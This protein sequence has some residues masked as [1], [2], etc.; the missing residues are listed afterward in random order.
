MNSGNGGAN[1]TAMLVIVELGGDLLEYF[2]VASWNEF[3]AEL[4]RRDMT[5]IAWSQGE[6]PSPVGVVFDFRGLH[7]ARRPL[8]GI[9]LTFCDLEG[10]E[11]TGADL[12]GAKLWSC[13]GADFR[14][15]RLRGA[16]FRGDISGCCF[17]SDGPELGETDFRHAFYSAHEPPTGLPAEALAAC[18]VVPDAPDGADLS[19]AVEELPLRVRATIHEVPW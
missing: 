4:V 13:R 9:D 1:R 8:A 5:P 2:D 16:R 7:G 10:A 11:F 15:A 14:N 18:E 6:R 12:R 17:D 19:P 3:M